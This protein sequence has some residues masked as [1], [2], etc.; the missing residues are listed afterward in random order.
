MHLLFV[1]TSTGGLSQQSV[2]ISLARCISRIRQAQ[3]KPN[4]DSTLEGENNS[5]DL[6]EKLRAL[7]LRAAPPQGATHV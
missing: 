3:T 7:D 4:S 2:V 1:E 6:L 5:L